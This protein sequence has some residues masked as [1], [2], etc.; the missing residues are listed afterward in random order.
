MSIPVLTAKLFIPHKRTEII[1]RKRLSEQ[2][3]KGLN[4][5]LILISA[6][7]GFGKTTL[8]TEWITTYGQPLSCCLGITVCY[9]TSALLKD[10][11]FTRVL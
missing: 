3:N 2:L 5:K 9:A 8:I 7:A 10:R 4:S 6:P 11:I 1:A